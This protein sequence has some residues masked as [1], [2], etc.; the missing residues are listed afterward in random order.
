MPKIKELRK[1]KLTWTELSEILH[2]QG[3]LLDNEEVREI[4]LVK[5]KE[6]LIRFESKTESN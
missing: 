2:K 3:K 5:P 6:I 4:T 1:V